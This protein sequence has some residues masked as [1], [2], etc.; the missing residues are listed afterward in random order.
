MYSIRASK[1]HLLIIIFLTFTSL[2][3]FSSIFCGA[4]DTNT[5]L[6]NAKI[7]TNKDAYY[8]FEDIIA[9]FNFSSHVTDT[10]YFA[11]GI[12]EDIGFNFIFQSEPIQG[13]FSVSYNYS[14]SL[15]AS[16]YSSPS[17]NSTLYVILYYYDGLFGDEICSY[18]PVTIIKSSLTCDYTSNISTFKIDTFYNLSFNFCAIE[19]QSFYPIFEEVE[20]KIIFDGEISEQYSTITNESGG[21]FIHFRSVH[22]AK[23]VEIHLLISTS[24]FF[25]PTN[26]LFQFSILNK[27]PF[28]SINLYKLRK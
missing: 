5:S 19:N 11:F 14:F 15:I 21:I 28:L 8:I 13:N 17:E 27:F 18:R 9:T 16:D 20:C 10:D 4:N 1:T 3:I 25:N 26:F 2:A 22:S 23:R 6:F 7:S 24:K 12:A